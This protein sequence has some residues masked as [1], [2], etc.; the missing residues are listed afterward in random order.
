M[1]DEGADD[2]FGSLSDYLK[3][4]CLAKKISLLDDPDHLGNVLISMSFF[5]LNHMHDAIAALGLMSEVDEVKYESRPNELYVLNNHPIDKKR[6]LA[7]Q[8][9]LENKRD[10]D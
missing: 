7:A 8:E 6:L 4:K 10:E 2:L 9:A 3:N 5:G 1:I